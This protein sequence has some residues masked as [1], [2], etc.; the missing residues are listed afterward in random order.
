MTRTCW[1]DS[2]IAR[3]TSA[4][5][6]LINDRAFRFT[7][8][9]LG[10]FISIIWFTILISS[11]STLKVTIFIPS[12]IINSKSRHVKNI[13]SRRM[14]VF[15]TSSCCL[16][17]V[18]SEQNFSFSYGS[19]H[20]TLLVEGFATKNISP[21]VNGKVDLRVWATLYKSLNKIISVFRT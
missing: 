13:F 3:R 10:T 8:W 16:D 19:R 4:F 11:L 15:F 21:S 18:H 7:S 12:S 1:C 20:G 14:W 5:L 9:F 2:V 17:I 6:M